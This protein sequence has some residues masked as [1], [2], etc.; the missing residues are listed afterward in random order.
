[1][2]QASII[3]ITQLKLKASLL[4]VAATAVLS[5]CH[6][7]NFKEAAYTALRQNDCQRNEIEVF[8]TRAYHGEFQEYE[9]TRDE[10]L[11]KTSDEEEI[12]SSWS[13]LKND[14]RES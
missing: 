9:R 13:I 1:M 5:G 11:R 6:T 14:S 8:C 10:L 2:I 3:N 12:K 4:T 7:I